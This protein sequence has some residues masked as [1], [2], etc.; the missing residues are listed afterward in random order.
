MKYYSIMFLL[1]TDYW[2]SL[3]NQVEMRYIISKP[4]RETEVRKGE[5]SGSR[6]SRLSMVSFPDT[7]SKSEEGQAHWTEINQ[8]LEED[9]Y[10]DMWKPRPK[11][12]YKLTNPYSKKMQRSLPISII[13]SKK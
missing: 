3:Q 6:K 9:D 12:P 11:A 5:W 4:F 2:H 7:S 13:K 10:F 8:E 1:S